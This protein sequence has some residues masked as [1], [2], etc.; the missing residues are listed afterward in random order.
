MHHVAVVALLSKP[1]P[2][3]KKKAD[4]FLCDG[5]AEEDLGVEWTPFE[6]TIKE[7]FQQVLQL[8]ENS[9]ST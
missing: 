1:N 9:I 8:G 4:C 3:K 2:P 7:T 5:R 6:T